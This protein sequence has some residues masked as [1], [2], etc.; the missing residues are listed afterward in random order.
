MNEF[1][2]SEDAQQILHLAIARQAEAGELS[3][4]QLFEI[5]AELNISAA[6]LQ[7]AE[8]DWLSRRGEFEERRAFNLFRRGKFQQ[9]L[10]RYLIV[11]LFLILLNLLTA[12]GL[13]WSLYIGLAWGVGV[14]LDAWKTYRMNGEDYEEAFQRWRQKRQ[15]KQTFNNLLNRWLSV[16]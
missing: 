6:D 2:R 4:V 15:I 1:Y 9:R 3:R 5:A 16:H 11:N 13:T 12:G 14:A 10:G 8:Q 7:A